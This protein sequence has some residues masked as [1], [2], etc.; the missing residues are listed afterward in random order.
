MIASISEKRSNRNS[1]LSTYLGKY[2]TK[3]IRLK[4]VHALN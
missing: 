1:I 4:Y 3:R 2:L